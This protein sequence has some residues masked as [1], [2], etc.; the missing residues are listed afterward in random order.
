MI[1]LRAKINNK[2]LHPALSPYDVLM[3]ERGKIY[4]P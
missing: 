3:R 1:K 4:T 2:M